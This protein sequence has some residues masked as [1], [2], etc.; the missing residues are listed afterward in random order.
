MTE[1][2]TNR[3]M[4]SETNIGGRDR[5]PNT[6]R[7]RHF[8]AHCGVTTRTIEYWRADGF[9]PPFKRMRGGKHGHLAYDRDEVH[10]WEAE[11][12]AAGRAIRVDGR[13]R[14]LIDDG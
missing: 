7:T 6:W 2:L 1:T 8:A 14:R 13:L 10:T 9:T 5:P 11:E 12:I 4:S 3:R